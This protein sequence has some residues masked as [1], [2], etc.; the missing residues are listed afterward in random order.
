MTFK[1][2]ALKTF[3]FKLHIQAGIPKILY[4]FDQLICFPIFSYFAKQNRKKKNTE[5]QILSIVKT[6]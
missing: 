1:A 6:L 2:L 3:V 4:S 5:I